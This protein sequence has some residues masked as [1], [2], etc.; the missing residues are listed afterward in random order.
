MIW[1]RIYLSLLLI[2]ISMFSCGNM[3]SDKKTIS[4]NNKI[5]EKDMTEVSEIYLAGGC[6]WGTEYFMQQIPGVL[7]TE[8]GY[9]NGKTDN[10]TY[11]EVCSGKSGHAE[12]VRVAYNPKQVALST[13]LELYFKTID[14]TAINRQGND[15]GSQYRTGIYFTNPDDE[16]VAKREL[17]ILQKQYTQPIVVEV[18]PLDNFF[19][20]EEYHQD[21]LEKNPRG[22][23]HISPDLIEWV[24][25]YTTQSRYSKPDR[26]ELKER[27]TP[28]QYT[29]TQE[30]GT[31]RAFQNEYWNEERAGIYVDITTGEPLFVSSDKFDSGCGWPA[32]SRP[33]SAELLVQLRDST[34]GMERIEVRSKLGDAHLGHVFPDG[35]KAQ[36]GLRYCINSAALRFISKADMEAEGYG[37]YLYLIK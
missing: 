3:Q 13:L 2:I 34:H 19:K 12:T 25:N 29:V 14:P 9:A 23:C 22:Y 21:Y 5:N 10:P 20:A 4:N 31:E 28:I 7:Q 33:I 6:F 15:V 32:F 17:E 27:L 16:Q 30:N 24:R 18:R 26:L 8:V 37:D 11:E 1:N 35:P 36:G